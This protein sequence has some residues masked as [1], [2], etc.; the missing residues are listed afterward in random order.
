MPTLSGDRS[1]KL[2]SC[3]GVS[4]EPVIVCQRSVCLQVPLAIPK[5][6]PLCTIGPDFGQA[7][8]AWAGSETLATGPQEH[9]PIPHVVP[10]AVA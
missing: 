10:V 6:S 2:S 4:P 5:A 1:P 9:K 8:A 3:E 7:K